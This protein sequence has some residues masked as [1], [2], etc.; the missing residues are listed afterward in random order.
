[1]DTMRVSLS[2]RQKSPHRSKL[3]PNEWLRLVLLLCKLFL[4]YPVWCMWKVEP[5]RRTMGDNDLPHRT[6]IALEVSRETRKFVNC[7]S[8][9]SLLHDF[10]IVSINELEFN[11]REKR[12]KK[13]TKTIKK[14]DFFI[15]QIGLLS[16]GVEWNRCSFD[17]KA[18]DCM[19]T[20]NDLC[21]FNLF[22]IFS[23]HGFKR[24]SFDVEP[25]HA[26]VALSSFGIMT[27]PANKTRS[28]QL[29]NETV[30]GKRKSSKG[31]EEREIYLFASFRGH[32]FY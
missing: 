13:S 6:S 23:C 4:K 24:L 3:V 32:H 20:C 8:G 31:D 30:V 25:A 26:S 5:N 28:S 10:L 7:C 9:S 27:R 2:L 29:A 19:M 11:G 12:R 22:E 15:A 1:M 21:E 14:I 17:W 18:I 16:W